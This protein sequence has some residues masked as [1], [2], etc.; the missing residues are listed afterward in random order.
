MDEEI[1]LYTIYLD[2]K[3]IVFGANLRFNNSRQ[4]GVKAFDSDVHLRL[5]T[6]SIADGDSL[7][8]LHYVTEGDAARM[9][10]SIANGDSLR[11]LPAADETSVGSVG[12]FQSRMAIL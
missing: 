5:R 6:I 10:V 4:V 9:L 3:A 12:W 8:E 7:R 2:P 1:E 11:E